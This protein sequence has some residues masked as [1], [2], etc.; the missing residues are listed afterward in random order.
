MKVEIRIFWVIL[1]FIILI[2][3]LIDLLIF[4]N[5]E[6]LMKLVAFELFLS[7]PIWFII[8]FINYILLGFLDIS[9]EESNILY[10]IFN[11]LLF[12]LLGYGQWFI[13]LPKIYMKLW[14]KKEMYNI[15]VNK[16][17]LFLGLIVITL[18]I[19]AVFLL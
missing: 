4:H 12:L 10:I 3:V 19:L 6:A 13:L 17:I 8:I 2:F 16:Y 14:G 18:Y 9:I 5:E 11:W 15:S 1:Q 7:V